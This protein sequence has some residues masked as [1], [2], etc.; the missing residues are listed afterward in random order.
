MW[1]R[2]EF[3]G[4]SAGLAM[5]LGGRTAAADPVKPP[6][7][8]VVSAVKSVLGWT[9]CLELEAAPFPVASWGYSDR[10]VFAFIP[11]YL[12]KTSLR[13][14]PFVVHVHGHNTTAEAAM[15]THRLREQLEASKQDAILLVPQGP[16]MAADSSCGKLE[17]P[18]GFARLVHDALRT[19][20]S[21]DGLRATGDVALGHEPGP[22][23][24]SAHSGGYHAAAQAVRHGGLEVSEV[25]LFD[26][27]YADADAFRD[28]VL[29]AKNEPR[30][31]RH[32][33][34]SYTTGGNTE[35]NTK[36]LMAELRKQGVACVE[37]TVEGT[38]SREQITLSTG[39]SIR[40][41]VGHTDV[42]SEYM[43][44]RDC[45]FASVLPRRLGTSWFEAK[46]GARP[47]ERRR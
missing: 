11:H 29:A 35:A 31:R 42:T 39:V 21:P 24:V 19:L 28:W 43:E 25:Y 47:L 26:A 20:R 6:A 1:S 5:V 3:L 14:P 36:W 8:R 22:V 44:L 30:A 41:Q 4:L 46:R 9:L 23:I 33:V 32:K 17:A 34:V 45:L 12:K 16:V 10:R 13:R 38:L 37:E 7:S 18:G 40:S 2:R 27:L 15:H